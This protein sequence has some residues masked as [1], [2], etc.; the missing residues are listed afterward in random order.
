MLGE[1]CEARVHPRVEAFRRLVNGGMPRCV[2]RARACRTGDLCSAGRG[3][4]ANST[5]RPVLTAEPPDQSCQCG[6]A[7]AA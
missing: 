5:T 2:S 6:L 1:A 4:C 3:G 7:A